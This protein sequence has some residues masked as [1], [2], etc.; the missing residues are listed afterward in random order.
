[1]GGLLWGTFSS[2]TSYVA[3]GWLWRKFFQPSLP[4]FSDSSQR[5]VNLF[6]HILM[7]LHAWHTDLLTAGHSAGIFLAALF[8]LFVALPRRTRNKE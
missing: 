3:A 2:L 1:M 5:V 7:P 4:A 6:F 8:V